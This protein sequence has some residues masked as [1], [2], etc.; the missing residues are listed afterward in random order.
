MESLRKLDN[1]NLVSQVVNFWAH[2]YQPARW[3]A[4]DLTLASQRASKQACG[5]SQSLDF[6]KTIKAV[7]SH[8]KHIV[9]IHIGKTIVCKNDLYFLKKCCL[10]Y[11]LSTRAQLFSRVQSITTSSGELS[12]TPKTYDVGYGIMVVVVFLLVLL[13]VVKRSFGR[14]MAL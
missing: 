4:K 8:N 13:Q 14:Q 2:P 6:L 9:S 12:E 5:V 7:I 3:N 11:H 1:N 10:S